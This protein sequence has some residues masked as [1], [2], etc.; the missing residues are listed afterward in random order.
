ML[1]SR[2]ATAAVLFQL[3]AQ[4][5]AHSDDEHSEGGMSGMDTAKAPSGDGLPD[6]YAMPS[7]A[8]LGM[9]GNMMLA[10]IVLMVLA[11]FLI[12]PIGK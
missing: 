4:T 11:W 8:G 9:H 12:L 7:Y 10:H 3:A 6:Y 2:Y 5:L 1:A